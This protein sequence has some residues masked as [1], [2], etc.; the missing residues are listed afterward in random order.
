M[1][2]R[3]SE[4]ILSANCLVNFVALCFSVKPFLFDF[5]QRK[6]ANFFALRS[7]LENW[8]LF[9]CFV[10]YIFYVFFF[11]LITMRFDYLV[12]NSFL[13][14]ELLNDITDDGGGKMYFF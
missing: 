4:L 10:V 9:K 1:F 5:L 2:N 6:L 7:E 13:H 3:S 8:F 12:L 14:L 11:N